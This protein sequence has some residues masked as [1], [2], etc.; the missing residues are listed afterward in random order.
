ML[1][2][3]VRAFIPSHRVS[4]SETKPLITGNLRTLLFRVTE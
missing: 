2:E 1:V 3:I 4:A